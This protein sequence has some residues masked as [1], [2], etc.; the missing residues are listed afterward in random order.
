MVVLSSLLLLRQIS[1]LFCSHVF[2]LLFLLGKLSRRNLFSF[3]VNYTQLNSCSSCYTNDILTVF[4]DFLCGNEPPRSK[5]TS[6][7][8]F[9]KFHKMRFSVCLRIIDF[10]RLSRFETVTV[11]SQ[12]ISSNFLEFSACQKLKNYKI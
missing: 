6:I 4:F 2:V 5:V 8:I 9:Y 12:K 10:S 3:P 11:K 1:L 7:I